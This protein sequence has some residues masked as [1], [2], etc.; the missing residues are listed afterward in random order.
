MR[1]ITLGIVLFGLPVLS[2]GDPVSQATTSARREPAPSSVD[3]G[4]PPA[5]QAVPATLTSKHSDD[6]DG[7]VILELRLPE[8]GEGA[9]PARRV[10]CRGHAFPATVSLPPPAE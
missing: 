9:R 4:N 3:R 2:S 7:A 5:F 8:K 6:E 1:V 10:H